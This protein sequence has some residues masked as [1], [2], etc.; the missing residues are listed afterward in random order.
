MPYP[1]AS[2]SWACLVLLLRS[3]VLVRVLGLLVKGAHDG[4]AVLLIGLLDL[5]LVGD[6]ELGLALGHRLGGLGGGLVG[7]QLQLVPRPHLAEQGGGQEGLGAGGAVDGHADLPALPH[8]GLQLG[9]VV[10]VQLL[11]GGEHEDGGVQV[12]HKDKVILGKLH[13]GGVDDGGDGQQALTHKHQLGVVGLG[14]HDPGVDGGGVAGNGLGHQ[15]D[16][17]GVLGGLGRRLLAHHGGHAGGRPGAGHLPAGAFPA[18]AS[19]AVAAAGQQTQRHD[20]CK[21]QTK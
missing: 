16:G 2:S 19:G 5:G 17:V 18:A 3:D 8:K 13:L 11:V 14:V 6:G 15:G 4:H 1:C 10:D 7:H 12:L 9:D 21:R 20:H